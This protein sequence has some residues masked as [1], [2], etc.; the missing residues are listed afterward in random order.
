MQLCEGPV[1][2]Q[3][4][5][6]HAR[7]L[8]PNFVLS[9]VKLCESCV[10]LQHGCEL[11]SRLLLRRQTRLIR[12]PRGERNGKPTPK[13]W[14]RGFSTF[15]LCTALFAF[16]TVANAMIDSVPSSVLPMSKSL[17]TLFLASISAMAMPPS[18]PSGFPFRLMLS[19]VLL[20][21]NALQSLWQPR[22]AMSLPCKLMRCRVHL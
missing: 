20:R 5:G 18:L 8:V 4:L 10:G 3:V 13:L 16:S 7:A 15:N 22:S 6:Q 9:N 19:M 17:I 1:L 2:H 12:K 14:R 21:F 11:M